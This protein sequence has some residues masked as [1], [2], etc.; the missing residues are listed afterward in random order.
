MKAGQIAM[1]GVFAALAVV[2]MLLGGLIPI[3]T[4]AAPM[5]AS[6]LL[7]PLLRDLSPGLCVGWYVVVSLLS[8]L[9]CP[10]RET[11]LVFCF[12]GWYPICKPKLDRLRTFSRCFWKLMIFNAAAAALYAVLIVLFRLEAVLKEWKETAPGWLVLM[13]LLGNAAFFVYD[14]VLGRLAAVYRLRRDR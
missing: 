10:D 3:G 12:L 9:F 11:A 2:L 8:A 13:L 6:L 5:L 14:V 4:Y 1:G 7:I